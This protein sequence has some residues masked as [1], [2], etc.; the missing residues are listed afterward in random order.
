MVSI[1]TL[2]KISILY[3]KIYQ[4]TIVEKQQDA[5]TSV[6]PPH[7]IYD[8]QKL[9]VACALEYGHDLSKDTPQPEFSIEE[10][11]DEFKSIVTS[12]LNR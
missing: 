10:T 12:I 8:V 7:L 11:V 3:A 4:Q 6:I 2:Q 9:I 1:G 5:E